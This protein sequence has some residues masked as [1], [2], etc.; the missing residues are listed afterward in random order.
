MMMD[1]PETGNTTKFKKGQC[2]FVEEDAKEPAAK[3]AKS[4]EEAEKLAQII[5]GDSIQ[6][7]SLSPFVLHVG[8]FGQKCQEPECL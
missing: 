4:D 6:T 7:S 3:K 1:G 2:S 5:F 8:G